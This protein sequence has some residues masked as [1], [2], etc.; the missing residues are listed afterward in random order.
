MSE[1]RPKKVIRLHFVRKEVINVPLVFLDAL[2]AGMHDR[3]KVGVDMSATKQQRDMAA[4]RVS[5]IL[6]TLLL[7]SLYPV[8]SQAQTAQ[9]AGIV[10]TLSGRAAVARASLPPPMPLRFKDDV[11]RRDRIS[12]AQKSLVRVLL[13]GKA[14]VTVRELSV[15]TID[16]GFGRANLD[17]SEGKVAVGVL[18]SRMRPGEVLEI[19]TPT[20]VAAVRGTFFA[21][22]IPGGPPNT[23]ITVARGLVSVSPHTRPGGPTI[24]VGPGQ[25]YDVAAGRLRTLTAEELAQAFAD[26]QSPPQHEGL[27]DE[28][29]QAFWTRQLDQAAASSSS[30]L[31]EGPWQ[32]VANRTGAVLGRSELS[33]VTGISNALS[34]GGRGGLSTTLSGAPVSGGASGGPLGS[35]GSNGFP[36]LGCGG[37]VGGG[38]GVGCAGTG[39]GA[40]QGAG[41]NK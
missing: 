37:G 8:T 35:S 20:A 11:Y 12:T 27:P 7:I 6:A 28:F 24:L 15:L 41:L 40:L 31:G 26:L 18:Q 13:G 1:E 29:R 32:S 3:R 22:E 9:P 39:Q 17:L 36:G 19:R 10:T 30:E 21:V 38:A 23:L 34:G 4:P 33:I 2:G 14:L 16:E 5:R 25:T